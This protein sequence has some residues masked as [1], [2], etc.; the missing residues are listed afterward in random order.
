MGGSS[1]RSDAS[2]TN[3]NTSE[4]NIGGSLGLTGD[5]MLA[6]LQALTAGT[7]S[8]NQT[9]V[10]GT[11]DTIRFLTGASAESSREIAG[12]NR[13]SILSTMETLA[14][15][16]NYSRTVQADSYNLARFSQE[17]SAVM[18][19]R[20][21]SRTQDTLNGIINATRDFAQRAMSASTGQGT[22]LQFL[23]GAS[24]STPVMQQGGSMLPVIIGAVAIG[25][26]IM[27]GDK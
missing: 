24:N 13:Y 5:Q 16:Y 3:T 4:I 6:A 23:P 10:G 2:N 22:P 1:P 18:F 27:F 11:V 8:N 26:I 9:N 19:D 14:D 17:N 12:T 25:A 7:V 15:S 20:T 21:A